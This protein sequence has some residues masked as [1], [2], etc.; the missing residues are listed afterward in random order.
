MELAFRDDAYARSCAA[1]VVS[2][3]AEAGIRLSRSVFYPM[4]GGQPGDTGRLRWSGGETAIADTRKSEDGRGCLLIP[5]DGAALPRPG[6]TVTAEL[7]WDRRHRL[8][9]MHTALHLL[10]SLVDGPVTGGQIGAEKSRLDFALAGE[11]VDKDALERELNALIQGG[12]EVTADWISSADLA[13]SPQLVRTMSVK[14]PMDGGQ[15]RTIR[16]GDVDYQPCGGTHVANTRE[17]G[18]V[19][20]GKVES[21]GKQNRRINLHLAD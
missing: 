20:V 2:A 3:D 8:M 9:R 7:D 13:A 12:H 11:S 5:A 15:V 21:K 6:D 10:C 4:G 1:E 18:A 14:P 17:I 16:I 19:R